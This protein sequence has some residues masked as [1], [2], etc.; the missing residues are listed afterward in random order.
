MTELIEKECRMDVL[1]F[2]MEEEKYEYN[3]DFFID[4]EKEYDRTNRGGMWGCL[5]VVYLCKRG[6]LSNG[7]KK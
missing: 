7:N 4:L 5:E 3:M 1:K 2:L 6:N